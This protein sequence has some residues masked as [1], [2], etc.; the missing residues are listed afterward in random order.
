MEESKQSSSPGVSSDSPSF[1]GELRVITV[2]SISVR[3]ER[4]LRTEC[5]EAHIQDLAASLRTDGQLQPIQVRPVAEGR[6]ELISGEH[7]WMAAIEAGIETIAALV[8]DAD[9]TNA[10]EVQL[11]EALK[12]RSL[13]PT[14][15]ERALARYAKVYERRFGSL[16]GKPGRP[17]KN[18]APR[19]NFVASAAAKFGISKTALKRALSRKDN[20]IPAA[21]RALATKAITEDQANEL[22]TLTFEQQERALPE[23]TGKSRAETRLIAKRIRSE[24]AAKADWDTAVAA[25]PDEGSAA[26][27]SGSRCR[28]ALEAAAVLK[29]SLETLDSQLAAGTLPPGGAEFAGLAESLG[30]LLPLVDRVRSRFERLRLPTAQS[31]T[32]AG[33]RL[34][35]SKPARCKTTIAPPAAA[36]HAS[37]T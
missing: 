31:V 2:S 5:D 28:Q 36:E 16:K 22:V 1:K 29:T 25:T 6:Y 12:Q 32:P 23:M 7:R 26:D 11:V 10:E 35:D 24:K 3:A 37:A 34:I 30:A 8:L 4:R 19:T 27:E 21:V 15:R 9:D 33:L 17:P 13:T 18:S 14:E 20:L